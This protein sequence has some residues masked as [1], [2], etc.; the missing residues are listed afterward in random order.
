MIKDL[1]NINKQD[2]IVFNEK[3]INFKIENGLKVSVYLSSPIK[4]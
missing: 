1:I 4:L 3:N 2:Q